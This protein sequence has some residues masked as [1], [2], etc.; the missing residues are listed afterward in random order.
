MSYNGNQ[1]STVNVS[2]NH[3]R[4]WFS[5]H[6]ILFAIQFMLLI[7]LSLILYAIYSPN[8]DGIVVQT[9]SKTI[10]KVIPGT[11]VNSNKY[12]TPLIVV[13]VFGVII[14]IFLTIMAYKN[15]TRITEWYERSSVM[16]R[17]QKAIDNHELIPFD[18]FDTLKEY[19]DI[20]GL[21]EVLKMKGGTDDDEATQ[22]FI[23]LQKKA[24]KAINIDWLREYQKLELE[25]EKLLGLSGELWEKVNGKV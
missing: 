5:Q 22:L 4:N 24:R 7:V 17:I 25:H 16:G 8:K 6:K 23:D 18:E 10:E 2:T 21:K 20:S 1:H 9:V 11:V 12:Q 15:W 3:R 19:L 13:A 14:T